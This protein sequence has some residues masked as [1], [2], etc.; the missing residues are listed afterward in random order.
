MSTISWNCRGMAAPATIR[1]LKDLCR[2]FQPAILF[3]METIAHLERVD[4]T[5]STL[6]FPNMHC[7]EA[8]GTSGGLCLYWK[9]SMD[10]I[11]K[12]SSQNFIHTEIYDKEADL[13]WCCTFVYAHPN[14]SQ[15]KLFWPQILSL[16]PFG[17]YPWCCMGDFNEILAHHE[18]EGL[19]E[20]SES[21][22]QLFRDLLDSSDLMDMA[23]KGCKFTWCSNPRQ[24]QVTK[25]KLDMIL[26]NWPWRSLYPKSAGIALPMVSSDHSPCCCASS[27]PSSLL[28]FLNSKQSGTKI[29]SVKK[30]SIKGGMMLF[31]IRPI[32]PVGKS[33]CP[34]PETARALSLLGVK[35]NSSVLIKR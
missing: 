11:I 12:Q 23:L 30:L 18:K 19:R 9:D 33:S 27:R 3:L 20:H 22:I 13:S 7:V 6:R 5:K 29:T 34:G 1:E 24:G 14:F 28:N 10:I 2:K 35:Q 16:K 32:Q 4:R 21:R 17:S 8:N 15:R 25:E 26:V 31:L